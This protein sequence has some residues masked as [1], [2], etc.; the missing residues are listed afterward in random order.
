MF[1]SCPHHT[2]V[3]QEQGVTIR[4][5]FLLSDF[6]DFQ[7]GDLLGSLGTNYTDG[8]RLDH[9]DQR[10]QPQLAC[11]GALAP[12]LAICHSCHIL[13]ERTHSS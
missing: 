10:P 2:A 6:V 13:G 3:P 8:F 1:S 11:D 12:A 4:V 9:R 5:G 7:T